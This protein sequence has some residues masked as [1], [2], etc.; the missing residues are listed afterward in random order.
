MFRTLKFLS[1]KPLKIVNETVLPLLS[2]SSLNVFAAAST[3]RNYASPRRNVQQL[4]I[5]EKMLPLMSPSLNV[6]AAAS[7][8]RNVGNEIQFLKLQDFDQLKGLERHTFTTESSQDDLCRLILEQN[9]TV[10]DLIGRSRATKG[11]LRR[12][13]KNMPSIVSFGKFDDEEDQI[14]V[15][16]A[17]NL[18]KQAKLKSC[19]EFLDIDPSDEHRVTRMEI[20]GSY[21]SQGLQKIRLPQEVFER[22]RILLIYSKGDFTETEKR[23][24]DEHV[25][26]CE[27]FNDWSSLGR[28][29]CRDPQS[30]R[31]YARIHIRQKEKNKRGGFTAEESK[32]VLDHVFAANKNAL[33]DIKM[34]SNVWADL[35]NC[36][37]R[38]RDYVSDH[39]LYPLQPLLTRYEAGV[40]DVDFKI[41]LLKYCI[42][43]DIMYAQ[44]ANWS[45]IS[46]DPNFPGTT[47]T[48]LSKFY[49]IM[50]GDAK[51][52]PSYKG[53]ADHEITT[54]VMLE[55][56]MT[57]KTLKLSDKNQF[58]V[59]EKCVL[60]YYENDIKTRI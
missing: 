26:G 33:E 1:V 58:K 35:A 19:V 46:K 43:K 36:L 55:Y 42:S 6:F 25:N 56:Q 41:P 60:D 40:L 15:E 20:I 4:G 29:L 54:K 44:N 51:K 50:R 48:Y 38:P 30:I 45:E 5:N 2:P 7:T 37:N 21:L 27:S 22:A 39:W 11:F 16:N 13:F 14:I 34:E 32:K 47:P 8:L 23:I 28:K 52:S 10:P 18:V 24:I 12:D 31:T 53:R 17:E 59:W 9:F 3:S 57:K 49:G